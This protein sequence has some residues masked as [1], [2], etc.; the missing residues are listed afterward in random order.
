MT[1]EEKKELAKLSKEELI[2]QIGD[3][4]EAYDKQQAAERRE[5][6]EK[7]FG[8]A[9]TGKEEP[10]DDDDDVLDLSKNQAFQD[11]QKKFK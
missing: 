9:K 8:G 11:L 7:F 4:K 3:M 2:E 5:I 10:E 1:D 6:I